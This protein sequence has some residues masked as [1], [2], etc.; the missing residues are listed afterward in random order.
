VGAAAG[1]GS[2]A[3]A[4]ASGDMA[5]LSPENQGFGFQFN[6]RASESASEAEQKGMIVGTFGIL[7]P[8]VLKNFSLEYPC[9]MLEMDIEWA[10]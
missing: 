9:S 6:G 1:L 2:A 7:H 8:E 5:G 4:F 10:L 3:P